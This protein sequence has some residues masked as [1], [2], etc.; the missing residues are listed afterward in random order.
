MAF[1]NRRMKILHNNGHDLAKVSKVS[2]EKMMAAL[3]ADGALLLICEVE[4]F[5]PG[6]KISVEQAIEAESMDDFE[7]KSEVSIRDSLKE[8]LDN[9]LFADCTIKVSN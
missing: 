9:E 2:R 3:K 4:Y 8:M 5:P 1:L 7:E 6:S